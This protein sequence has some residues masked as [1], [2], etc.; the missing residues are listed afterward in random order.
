MNNETMKE[1][2]ELTEIAIKRETQQ[3]NDEIY[4]QACV[5]AIMK[6]V[7]NV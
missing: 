1:I 6:G 4:Q 7:K 5:Y 2:K 3:A